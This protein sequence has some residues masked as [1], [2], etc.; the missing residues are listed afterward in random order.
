MRTMEMFCPQFE[1]LTVNKQWWYRGTCA[2]MGSNRN[3]WGQASQWGE[4]LQCYSGRLEIGSPRGSLLWLK[5]SMILDSPPEVPTPGSC[6]TPPVRT[7]L[8]QTR[9]ARTYDLPLHAAA[10]VMP[11]LFPLHPFGWTQD[12]SCLLNTVLSLLAI[13]LSFPPSFWPH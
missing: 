1:F 3:A 11:S 13:L 4:V 7:T 5:L 9:Q 2:M 12:S 6:S 10:V 8:P